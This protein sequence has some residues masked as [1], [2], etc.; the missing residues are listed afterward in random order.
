MLVITGIFD[1]ERFIPDK[2]VNIP[3]K[4]KVVV[5]IEEQNEE[6]RSVTDDVS[7]F[8]MEPVE[9]SVFGWLKVYANP[10]LISKEKGAWEA[11]AAEKHALR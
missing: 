10:S 9:H 11:A 5:T 2:P 4:T 1:N 8:S 7:G 3:Q 6:I